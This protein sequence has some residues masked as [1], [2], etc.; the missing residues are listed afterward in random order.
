MLKSLILFSLLILLSCGKES[1]TGLNSIPRVEGLAGTSGYIVI[2]NSAFD[3]SSSNITI[4]DK[5]LTVL[6]ENIIADKSDTAVNC[7]KD[8]FYH[9]GRY[10]LD[11]V[12]FYSNTSGFS[13][14]VSVKESDRAS[15]NPYQVIE[16]KDKF[17]VV[18]FGSNKIDL[19]NKA[20]GSLIKAVDLS[21]FVV[22]DSDGNLE[23]TFAWTEGNEVKIVVNKIS[24]SG[25]YWQFIEK[26][27]LVT[28]NDSLEFMSQRELG[29]KNYS[30][31]S[32]LYRGN[33]Y[34]SA[35]GDMMDQNDTSGGIENLSNGKLYLS[36]LKIK[37]IVAHNNEL[38]AMRFI[39]WG[40]YDVIKLALNS[41]GDITGYS[42]LA[43]FKD[44]VDLKDVNGDLLLLRKNSLSLYNSAESALKSEVKL[45]P[46][47]QAE[48]LVFCE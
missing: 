4:I 20:D 11:R 9:I 26:P 35:L 21:Q 29:L 2:K 43:H 27:V 24:Q 30:S 14:Q 15:T 8:G 13:W 33:K 31:P 7:A 28:L 6:N 34:L 1:K 18:K 3:F 46:S 5:D 40:Q 39:S 45:N 44:V 25:N 23:P 32:L 16:I 10:Q 37:N 47:F 22:A 12:S 41:D 48:S 36:G 17:I 38:F 42:E 19:R